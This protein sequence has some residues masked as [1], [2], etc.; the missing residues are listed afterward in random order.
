LAEFAEPLATESAD[1]AT[2]TTP[3]GKG[4]Q[5]QS[6]DGKEIRGSQAHAQPLT[7]VSWVQHGTGI[8]LAQVETDTKSNE[9]PAAAQLVAGR[10]LTNTV[11]TTDA[12]H[13]QRHLAQQILDQHG[14]YL[15]VVKENQ[16]KIWHYQFVSGASGGRAI[17]ITLAKA[18]DD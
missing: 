8:T 2:I 16:H 4:L 12:L 9:I 17:G 3:E 14:H 15:M 1:C 6:L 13:T 10:D 7:L 11:T 18:L 5:G